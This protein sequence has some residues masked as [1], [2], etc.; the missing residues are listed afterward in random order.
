MLPS[1]KLLPPDGTAIRGSVIWLHGLGADGHDFVPFVRQLDLLEQG[2]RFILPHAPVIPVTINGGMSMP[3]WYDILSAD[4]FSPQAPETIR[5]DADGIRYSQALIEQLIEQEM[6]EQDLASRQI[7]L[8]GFSQGGAIALQTG[9]RYPKPLGGILALSTYLPQ[10][11]A[12]PEEA[13]QENR[14][15]PILFMHGTQDDVVPASAA[16][17]SANLL[18]DMG[19]PVDWRDYPIGHAVCTPQIRVIRDWILQCLSP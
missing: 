10:S 4:F 2:I 12:L 3:A 16:R 9:L 6:T 1:E 19:Y 15:T 8:A 14:S 5:E 18:A 13:S 11:S 7:I 17:S